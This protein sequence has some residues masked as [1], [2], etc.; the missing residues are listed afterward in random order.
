M[1]PRFWVRHKQR[2]SR[3]ERRNISVCT[4]AEP[5]ALSQEKLFLAVPSNCALLV[6]AANQHLP[7]GASDHKSGPTGWRQRVP[8]FGLR[9]FAVG[10]KTE[11]K[12]KG[13]RMKTTSTRFGRKISEA[14]ILPLPRGFSFDDEHIRELCA[15]AEGLSSSATWDEIC[16][17]RARSAVA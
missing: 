4:K 7:E 15:E 5:V 11:R 8:V 17:R 13:A 12:T 1:G 2:G 9:R 16:A 14:S 3:A 10:G 6:V